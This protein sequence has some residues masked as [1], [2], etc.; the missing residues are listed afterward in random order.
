MTKKIARFGL[1]A[2]LLAVAA[3]WHSTLAQDKSEEV[4][5]KIGVVRVI[6]QVSD[7]FYPAYWKNDPKIKPVAEPIDRKELLRTIPLIRQF[8]AEYPEGV[9]ARNLK[10]IYLCKTLQFYGKDFGG[11]N[12]S[13]GVY[14]CVKTKELGYTNQFVLSSMHHEF[15]SILMRNF[16]F[17]KKEW[18]T[19]N[20][21]DFA[22]TEDAVGALGQEDLLLPQAKYHE[23]G[24]VCLYSQSSME[25]DFNT[26]ADYLFNQRSQLLKM[27]KKYPK[28]GA[29]IQLAMK[30][31]KSVD[32]HFSFGDLESLNK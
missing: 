24:F 27:G 7:A 29:K 32:S 11:T 17:P 31:Y 9:L 20:P 10:G 18:A 22:Y 23:L 12:S 15:S 21:K 5:D 4:P 26:I 6:H 2:I 30:F 19:L 1:I 14:I 8:V 28:L 13:D 3:N 25:E 16:A